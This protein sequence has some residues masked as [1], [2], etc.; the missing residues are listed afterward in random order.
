MDGVS[1]GLTCPVQQGAAVHCSGTA[2]WLAQPRQPGSGPQQPPKSG[3]HLSLW[4]TVPSVSSDLLMKLPS[5][6]WLLFT[7]ACGVVRW[8]WGHGA[9]IKR[10]QAQESE[11]MRPGVG[12]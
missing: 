2:R 1:L 11:P 8:R 7:S 3:P 4:M 10:P 5:M 6:R 9:P 12:G